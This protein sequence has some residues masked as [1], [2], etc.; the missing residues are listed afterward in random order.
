MLAAIAI[1]AA[2]ALLYTQPRVLGAAGGHWAGRVVLVAVV[3]LC[4]LVHPALGV[5]A[6][7][8][9]VCSM[10]QR[11]GMTVA[12]FRDENCRKGPNGSRKLVDAAGQDV[13][14]DQVKSVHPEISFKGAACN[15]CNSDCKFSLL[16]VESMVQGARK[17]PPGP[18]HVTPTA[19]L[20]KRLAADAQADSDE[21]EASP[22]PLPKPKA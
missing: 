21:P 6:A 19:L 18:P 3:V 14:E 12:G 16:E 11:E 13:P 2:L 17:A 7:A 9:Y 15:P 1:V 8:I 4:A 5:L 20:S 22:E 10:D